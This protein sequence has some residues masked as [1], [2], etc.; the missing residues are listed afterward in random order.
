MENRRTGRIVLISLVTLTVFLPVLWSYFA[1]AGSQESTDDDGEIESTLW[2]GAVLLFF[3]SLIVGAV[4]RSLWLSLLVSVAGSVVVLVVLGA[5]LALGYLVVFAPAGDLD[6]GF[7]WRAA[8]IGVRALGSAVLGTAVGYAIGGV[9]RWLSPPFD[10][11]PIAGVSAALLLVWL[12]SEFVGGMIPTGRYQ[13]STHVIGWLAGDWLIYRPPS[14]CSDQVSATCGMYHATWQGS[15]PV[16]ATV[17]L[18]AL[19]TGWVA[20]TQRAARGS[21]ASSDR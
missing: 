17:A 1:S 12:V 3:W 4:V 18:V 13:L 15:L 20:R 5:T 14:D 9:A 21:Q 8:G 7:W 10:R 19:A 2:G 16:L 11:P 6:A